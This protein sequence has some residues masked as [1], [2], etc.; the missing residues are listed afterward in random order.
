MACYSLLWR[1]QYEFPS[2][3]AAVRGS[4]GAW[5]PSLH[6]H[7]AGLDILT[8][9]LVMVMVVIWPA[10]RGVEGGNAI[11]V[12][13]EIL[14]VTHWGGVV[15][16]SGQSHCKKKGRKTL[17]NQIPPAEDRAHHYKF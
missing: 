3:H 11:K 12:E 13:D 2:A 7:D 14:S 16:I 9:A 8:D 5:A 1:A 10:G 17:Q 4:A 6:S 15:L